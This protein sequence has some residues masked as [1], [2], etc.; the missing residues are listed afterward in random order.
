MNSVLK[1][2]IVL[3]FLTL[4]GIG[5]FVY[6]QQGEPRQGLFITGGDPIQWKGGKIRQVYWAKNRSGHQTLYIESP[7]FEVWTGE[8]KEKKERQQ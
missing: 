4:V 6:A 3:W 2:V 7:P 8:C 5:L 1:I